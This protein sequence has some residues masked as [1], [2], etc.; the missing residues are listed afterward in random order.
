[1]VRATLG[2][3][4]GQRKLDRVPNLLTNDLYLGHFTLH[5]VEVQ[6]VDL[7]FPYNCQV[8]L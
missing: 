1:M 2:I 7:E 5:G 6:S 4:S 8:G 3:P